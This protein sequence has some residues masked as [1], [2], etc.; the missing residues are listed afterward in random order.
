MKNANFFAENG[1]KWAKMGG[2]GRKWAKIVIIPLTPRWTLPQ[3]EG[4]LG[5]PMAVVGF[6]VCLQQGDQIRRN[7]PNGMIVYFGQFF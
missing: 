2:N 4:L 3:S 6:F 7:S 5:L 1:R